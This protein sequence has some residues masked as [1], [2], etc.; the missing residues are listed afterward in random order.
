MMNTTTLINTKRVIKD[1]PIYSQFFE[2]DNPSFC[3]TCKV[4]RISIV[5]SFSTIKIR[6]SL[7]C[8]FFN[9]SYVKS[10]KSRFHIFSKDFKDLVFMKKSY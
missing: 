8:S 1:E 3:I 5:T 6:N 10:E 9:I 2:S 7:K 4:T